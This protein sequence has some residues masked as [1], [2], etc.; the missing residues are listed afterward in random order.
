MVLAQGISL[1]SPRTL[2]WLLGYPSPR[3]SSVVRLTLLHNFRPLFSCNFQLVYR[4]FFAQVPEVQNAGLE[5]ASPGAEVFKTPVYT[6][7]TSSAC[8]PQANFVPNHKAVALPT[9]LFPREKREVGLEP[10]TYCMEIL[11]RSHSCL[12]S[13]NN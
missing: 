5:P 11:C 4:Y 9:E 7:S 6:N 13:S 10:T 8:C 2:A 12:L 1:T 3:Y